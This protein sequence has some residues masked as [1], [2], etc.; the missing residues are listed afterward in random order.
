[1]TGIK[2]CG[3]SRPED[4]QTANELKV[5]Y[6]GFVFAPKS[7]RYVAPE[8]AA[9]LKKLLS[10]QIR[11]VVVNETPETVAERLCSGTIGLAQLHGQEDG[12][13]IQQLRTLTD[14]PIIQAFRIAS[15]QDCKAAQESMADHILLDSGAGTGETFDWTMIGQVQRPY[16]LAGGL[17]SENAANCVRR[18]QPYAVDV[19]SGIETNG[20]KDPI[21][22]AEFVS[23]VRKEDRK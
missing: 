16:F 14:K 18:L 17:S 19:S 6:I 1:M 21:K 11:A 9:A 10:P 22:M 12:D 13:Y 20:V 7:R 3:L 4:I 2:L 5:D 23:A 8:R 15:A